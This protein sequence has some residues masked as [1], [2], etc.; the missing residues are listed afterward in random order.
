LSSPRFDHVYQEELQNLTAAEETTGKEEAKTACNS[1]LNQKLHALYRASTW[2]LAM[3]NGTRACQIFVESD[4][5]YSDLKRHASGELGEGVMNLV[6]RE[7]RH[8][9]VELEF[10]GFIYQRKFT[11]LTQYN[12]FC[13]FPQLAALQGAIAERIKQDFAVLLDTIPLNNYVVDFVLATVQEPSDPQLVE[14]NRRMQM[15][16][17]DYKVWVI[18]LNP[19]AE[20]AGTGLFNWLVDKPVLLGK[21][22][23]EFRYHTALPDPKLVIANMTPSWKAR[24]G[25]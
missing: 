4:R 15:P 21:Q 13:Y 17:Q 25:L 8:F 12:E 10:R 22:P 23:F 11:A 5:T 7:F 1:T 2:C 9:P 19:M 14:K 16:L 24:L 18:E 3:E 20:F 6:V